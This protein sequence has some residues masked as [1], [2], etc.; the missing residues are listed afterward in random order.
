ML[1]FGLEQATTTEVVAAYSMPQTL[2]PAVATTPGWHVG[3]TFYLPL[4]VKCRLD[5]LI[6]VSD[7]AV[8]ANV[9]LFDLTALAP[10]SGMAVTSTSATPERKLSP[11]VTLTGNRRYQ[12]QVEALGTPGDDA[13]A[14]VSTASITD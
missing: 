12:I 11:V 9:R 8:T 4:T 5:A 10:V 13:Y 6:Q 2:V 1:S 14:V 7:G 3:G